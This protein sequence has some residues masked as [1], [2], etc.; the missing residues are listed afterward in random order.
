[1]STP[2]NDQDLKRFGQLT[3]TAWELEHALDN[4][5]PDPELETQ[6]PRPARAGSMAL[7]AHARLQGEME[8]RL[9]VPKE[10]RTRIGIQPEVDESV[11]LVHG[12]TGTPQDL[13]GLARY[14]HGQGYTVYNMLLPGHGLES[15]TLPVVKW[16]ACLNEVQLRYRLL[17][18]HSRLVHVVGFSF[19][20][21][22]AILL[23][24]QEQPASLS[25]LAPALVPRVPLGTRLLMLLGLH[26][27]PPLRRRI[28]W[29]LEVF[30]A[31][32]RAKSQ[33]GKLRLPIYAA[34]CQDDARIDPASLRLLQKRTRHRASR[35]RLFETGGHMILAAHGET[36]LN[37][38]LLQFLRDRH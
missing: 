7:R 26:R 12:S 32:E 17:A 23:T 6:P 3:L 21:A 2:I 37:D 18:R 35:F 29:N 9:G 14:L 22:L 10:R 16:K 38:A 4:V 19:G 20:G 24:R 36:A 31:M 30:E 1:V 33:V 27:L 15:A 28:G 25:L 34:H 13:D 11:L 8:A 5:E